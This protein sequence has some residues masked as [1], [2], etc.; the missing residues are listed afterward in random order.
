MSK[1]L[2][3]I[4]EELGQ[5]LFYR[6]TRAISPTQFGKDFYVQTI[7]FLESVH[8]I[9]DQDVNNVKLKGLLKVT[10]SASVFNALFVEIIHEFIEKYPDVTLDLHLS[11]QVVDIVDKG[12]DLAIR[13]SDLSDS[14]LK[15]L[16]LRDSKRVLC[17]SKNYIKKYGRPKVLKDLKD[18]NCLILNNERIW[19]FKNNN[20]KEQ[21]IVKGNLK[22]NL[23][24]TICDYLTRDLGVALIANWHIK[25]Q[26]K[27][28]SII[29]LLPNY[30]LDSTPS[31]FIV[32]PNIKKVPAKTRV[33]IDF[34]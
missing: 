14:S 18:H 2:V 34:K 26:L 12:Y 10:M 33:F 16:K 6:T 9:F 1:K 3:L 15:C 17:A 30:E 21:V 4:E 13:V 7:D 31:I 5:T 24:D 32:Y 23:G 8:D 22:T 29:Q 27:E 28:K 25:K 20:K 19:K 11:D